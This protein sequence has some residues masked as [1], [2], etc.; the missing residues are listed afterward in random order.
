MFN[1]AGGKENELSFLPWIRGIPESVPRAEALAPGA[2]LCCLVAPDLGLVPGI[3]LLLLLY[4]APGWPG[5]LITTEILRL[6][7]L[8]KV[9]RSRG[10]GAIAH[11]RRI[12]HKGES[13]TLS[14][15]GLPS[16]TF[17]NSRWH[18]SNPCG[19]QQQ[20]KAN[21]KIEVRYQDY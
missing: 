6:R 9:P 17:S 3:L 19:I 8:D 15:S 21:K 1:W 7:L 4:L 14:G 2:L 16:Y 10:H 18:A 13:K 11:P 12:F 20:Y 5:L